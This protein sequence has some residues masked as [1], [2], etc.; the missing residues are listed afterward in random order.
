SN[1]QATQLKCNGK[2]YARLYT[3][4]SY[5]IRPRISLRNEDILQDNSCIMFFGRV[6]WYFVYEY[7][8]ASIML[9]YIECANVSDEN[10]H[11]LG[12]KKFHY[13]GRK[14]FIDIKLLKD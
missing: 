5:I 10:N 13:F 8:D 4:D 7:N 1:I 6:L 2:K 12:L 9:A 14:N 11:Q 3:I